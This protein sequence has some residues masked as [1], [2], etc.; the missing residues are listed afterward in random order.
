L[1]GG[2]G[3]YQKKFKQNFNGPLNNGKNILH[4]KTTGKKI[5]QRKCDGFRTI[6]S[7]LY[8][9]TKIVEFRKYPASGSWR[10]KNLAHLCPTKKYHAR[11]NCPTPLKNLMVHP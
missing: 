7:I 11:K 9:F 2:G 6:C 8:V 1:R 3:K 10:K 4:K 5:V